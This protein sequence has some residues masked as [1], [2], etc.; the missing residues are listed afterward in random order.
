MPDEKQPSVVKSVRHSLIAL[1]A[2]S[3]IKNYAGAVLEAGTCASGFCLLVVAQATA[4]DLQ[5]LNGVHLS[6]CDI[7]KAKAWS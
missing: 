2:L 5:G 1:L 3:E 4:W 6:K 7:D